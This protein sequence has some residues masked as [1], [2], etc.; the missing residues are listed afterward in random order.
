MPRVTELIGG[1]ESGFNCSGFKLHLWHHG[2]MSSKACAFQTCVY[3]EG[4]LCAR[5][6]LGA[7]DNE[8]KSVKKNVF[9]LS[10]GRGRAG[11]VRWGSQGNFLEEVT[12]EQTHRR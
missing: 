12:L 2:S 10:E 1:R 9:T 8:Q 11:A 6:V 3:I 7:W 4:L 5:I